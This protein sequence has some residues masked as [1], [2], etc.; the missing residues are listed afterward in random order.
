[1]ASTGLNFSNFTPPN[2]AITSLREL[3]F[4][5]IYDPGT[6]GAIF[7]VLTGQENGKK[8]GFIGEFGMLGK[9]AQGC[10]PNYDNNVINTGEKTWDINWWGIY[11]QICYTDLEPFLRMIANREKTD[12]GNLEGTFY[13]DEILEPRLQEAIRKLLMRLAWFGDKQAATVKNGGNLLNTVDPAYFNVTDGFWKRFFELTTVNPARR[14]IIPAN[15]ED[16]FADQDSAILEP[17]AAKA[18]IKNLKLQAS[19]L[20]KQST[21]KI[22]YVTESIKEA[23]SWDV[24]EGHDGCCLVWEA[25]FDGIE[26]T[27]FDGTT[28]IS[29]PIWDDIIRANEGLYT[30]NDATSYRYPHRAVYTTTDNL[31]LGTE[32]SNLIPELKTWFDDKD[33]VNYIK[34]KDNLGTMIAQDELVQ[35]A[36]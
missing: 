11:E 24:R 29:F 3:I 21:K 26:I 13:L 7:N 1:M 33:E 14:T 27:Q 4:L 16:T 28:I 10:K 32:S 6:L 19:P 12:I 9:K 30:D 20:L 25:L 34:A 23:L 35:V 18:V 2:G 17:G 22:I 15:A 31:L 5:S 36:Y 8:V